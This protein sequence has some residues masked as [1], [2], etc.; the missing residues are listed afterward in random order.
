MGKFFHYF[1][2]R[3]KFSEKESWRNNLI[4]EP[5]EILRL[6]E[7]RKLSIIFV[8]LND[9]KHSV[10]VAHL[11]FLCRL[12]ETKLVVLKSGSA[13]ELHSYFEKKDL[14]MFAVSK[15]TESTNFSVHF[16]EFE[17]LDPSL[18]PQMSIKK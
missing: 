7:S 1:R 5:N 9:L 12:T 13:Q 14:F 3:T 2:L 11:P 18:L 10:H 8:C 6:L 16:P 4:I 15:H 17:K